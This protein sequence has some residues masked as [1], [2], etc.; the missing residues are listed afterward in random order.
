M[1]TAIASSAALA[2]AGL[3]ALSLTIA[4]HHADV[5]GRAV[6]ATARRQHA[7]ALLGWLSLACSFAAAIAAS[8]WHLG[9][10][11]WSGLLFAA[12][13]AHTLLL[14]LAPRAAPRAAMLSAAAGLLQ[15]LL[16]GLRLLAG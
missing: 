15:G 2:Y 4:R 16:Q 11:L 12:A 5:Y 7:L 14:W 10:V 8:G 6:P 13:A 3:A 1:S 9:P